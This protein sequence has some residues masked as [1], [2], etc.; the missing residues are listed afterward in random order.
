MFA[1]LRYFVSLVYIRCF[2]LFTAYYNLNYD[3]PIRYCHLCLL[4]SPPTLQ[5]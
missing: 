5:P 4:Y 1:L 2:K 3:A